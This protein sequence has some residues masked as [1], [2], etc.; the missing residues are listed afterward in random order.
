VVILNDI[1]IARAYLAKVDHA[2]SNNHEFTLSF[3]QF[4]RIITRKTCYYT[5]L[6]FSGESDYRRTLDRVDNSKGYI[7]GNVVVCLNVVNNI[8]SALE[9]PTNLLTPKHLK[10]MCEIMIKENKSV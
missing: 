4:K 2:K 7:P 5:S 3:S 10:K 8:K 6:P 9:N 1:I